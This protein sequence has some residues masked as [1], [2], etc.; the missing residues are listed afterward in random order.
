MIGDRELDREIGE[1]I[2]GYWMYHYDK[3]YEANCYWALLD[4]ELTCVADFDYGK[5][6]HRHTQEEAWQDMPYFSRDIE[7]AWNVVNEIIDVGFGFGIWSVGDMWVANFEQGIRQ[8]YEADGESPAEAICQAA[9]KVV[10]AGHFEVEG[11][12]YA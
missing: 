9:M 1:K 2:F 10:A 5:L 12:E 3:D 6:P 11:P 4:P 7:A 8:E